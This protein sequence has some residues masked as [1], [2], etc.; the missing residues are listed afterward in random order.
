MRQAR[1]DFLEIE[2]SEGQNVET[3]LECEENTTKVPATLTSIK[4]RSPF[5]GFFNGAIKEIGNR[6]SEGEETADVHNEFY[7]PATFRVLS[8]YI[9]LIPLWSCMM[10][11]HPGDSDDDVICRSNAVIESH[12]KTVKHGLLRGRKRLRPRE[13]LSKNLT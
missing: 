9:H 4:K 5:T 12:F 11:S 10:T 8:S 7:S 1:T 6:V 2:S 13:F 3:A